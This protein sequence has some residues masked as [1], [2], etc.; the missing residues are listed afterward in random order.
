VGVGVM[1]DYKLKLR[2]LLVS[3]TLIGLGAGTPKDRDE[4]NN[5]D[6]SECNG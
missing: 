3:H 4:V 5:R 1:K 2:N 6:V